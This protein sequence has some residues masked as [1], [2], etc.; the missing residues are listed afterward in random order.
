MSLV[1]QVLEE[2]QTRA[3]NRRPGSPDLKRREYFAHLGSDGGWGIDID[4]RDLRRWNLAD[5]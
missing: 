4:F 2:G 5:L 1:H 3:E